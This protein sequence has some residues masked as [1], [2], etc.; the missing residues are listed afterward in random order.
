[1]KE[2]VA[3]TDVRTL[4]NKRNFAVAGTGEYGDDAM[5]MDTGMIGR[6][7]SG[8]MRVNKKDAKLGVIFFFVCIHVSLFSQPQRKRHV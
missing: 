7:G 5:G 4:A 8:K 2:R 3:M 6:E 1:M